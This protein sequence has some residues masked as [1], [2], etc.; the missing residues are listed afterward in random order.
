[1]KMKIHLWENVFNINISL[2][3]IIIYKNDIYPIRV[4]V[5]VCVCYVLGVLKTDYEN[6]LLYFLMV[7]YYCCFLLGFLIM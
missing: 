6:I 4:C 7:P 1:M 2:G 5:C 3:S